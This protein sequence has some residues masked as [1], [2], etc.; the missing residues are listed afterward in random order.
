MQTANWQMANASFRLRLRLRLWPNAFGDGD[1][2]NF[3]GCCCCWGRMQNYVAKGW[4]TS[5]PTPLPPWVTLTCCCIILMFIRLSFV[6]FPFPLRLPAAAAH[7]CANLPSTSCASCV[8]FF[9]SFETASLAWETFAFRFPNADR[10]LRK[11]VRSF[12]SKNLFGKLPTFY[13][14]AIKWLYCPPLLSL[15]LSLSISVSIPISIC[16][17]FSLPPLIDRWFSPHLP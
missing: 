14:P 8:A 12:H 15:S 9:S 17:P 6:H 2:Q 10:L 5:L 1:V 11:L 4:L 16:V 13:M 3:C 7:L